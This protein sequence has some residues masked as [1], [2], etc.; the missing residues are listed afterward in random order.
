MP[1]FVRSALTWFGTS[2]LAIAL[3]SCG[4][5]SGTEASNNS[6]EAAQSGTVTVLAGQLGGNGTLDG[7][8]AA[9][10]FNTPYGITVDSSGNV[11][12]ADT[13]NHT[14]RKIAPTGMVSTFAGAAGLAGA[15]NGHSAVARFNTPQGIAVDN[16]GNILVADTGNHTI[17]KITPTG[18]VSTFAGAA[19]LAGTTNGSR[20]TA[21][22]YNPT[23]IT[24]D[25]SGNVF[26]T[27]TNNHTIRKI[28]PAGQ[29]S[30]FA[31]MAGIHGSTDGAGTDALLNNPIK[32][33]ID[34]VDNLFVTTGS[35]I[36]KI[37]PD[38]V[39]TTHTGTAGLGNTDGD[40]TAARFFFPTG[41]SADRNGNI[42]VADMMNSTI[43][44]IS[45]A[46]MVSTLAGIPMQFGYADGTGAEARFSWVADLAVSPS[47]DIV[48]AD[49]LND[50]IRKITPTGVV[51]TLAGK[52]VP[53]GAAD[54][55]EAAAFFS[56]PYGIARDS[57]GNLFVADTGNNTIRKI[58]PAGVVTTFA[59]AAGMYGQEDGTGADARFESVT[60][61]AIDALNNLFVSDYNRIRMISPAGHVTTLAGATG[62]SGAGSSDGTGADAQFNSPDALAVDGAGNVF[63]ADRGN[64][65]I[66]K[67]TPG[68]VVTTLA[69]T[70]GMEGSV[71][72]Q[73]VAARFRHLRSLVFD[74]LG[75]IVVA[76]GSTIRK[77][78]PTGDV[79]TVAGSD[80]AQGTANGTGRAARFNSPSALAAD[81]AGNVFVA[82]NTIRKITPGGVVTTV[83]GIPGRR[84]VV[85]GPLPTS[86]NYING[87]TMGLNG[88]FYVTAEAAVIK[89]VLD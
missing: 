71:D 46:G 13:V 50:T 39:V 35:V 47:G 25:S 40:L 77:I 48:A 27:D 62:P 55:T 56:N 74:N 5:G 24:V 42:F 83:A 80:L 10:R 67:V 2:M 28:T 8:G 89:V 64:F 51:T 58:T 84:G 70:A 41:I 59:G 60:A 73:G 18:M 49:F 69:G 14:I 82:D 66:R 72:A 52:A 81:S 43:R 75:N 57:L 31:G 53:R 87:M 16:N 63:V 34:N 29:V 44:Q 76:D 78:T 19:G 45:D 61:I 15:A 32:I 7:N 20:A 88:E 9:A 38:G 21:R 37:T 12:V 36:R 1:L 33:T 79:S 30:T 23:G 11:F 26:V 85:P 4:G 86:L 3:T 22:F 6:P 54:G 65:T 17:R 68:G